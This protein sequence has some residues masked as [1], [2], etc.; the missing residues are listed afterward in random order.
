MG[1]NE[2]KVSACP[3]EVELRA[4]HARELLP[5]AA[6]A[7]DTHLEL[8]AACAS[9]A[10]ELLSE[11]ELWVDR[12]R[13]AGPAP[14]LR[15]ARGD[16]SA[17]APALPG[18]TELD[19]L[20]RGG[21]GVVYAATQLST[22]RRVALKV[23][24]DGVYASPKARR[25]FEREV[26]LVA[27]LQHAAIVT[28]HDFGQTPDGRQFLV[29]DLIEG[30][31]LLQA[32]PDLPDRAA[33]LRLFARICAAIA[34]AHRRGVIHRDL[35]PNNIL[36]DDAGEPH[37]LDFGL[38]R[39][40]ER[41]QAARIT[42]TERVAGTLP[43]MSP[44][45]A[46]GADDQIDVRSD[47]YALG[48]IL[49]ELLTGAYPYRVDGDTLEVLQNIT[50]AVPTRPSRALRAIGGQAP[51]TT[52]IDADLETI[53]LKA[54][55]KE[56]ERRYQ[57]AGELADDVTRHLAGEPIAARRDSH[58]YVLRKT[59][60]RYRLGVAVALAFVAVVTCSAVTLGLMASRQA[61][62]RAEAERR[63]A[64][65]RELAHAFVHEFDDEIR[66]L[67]GSANARRMVVARGLEYVDGLA[68]D[69]RDDPNLQME[70]AEAYVKI[71]DV[72]GGARGN[73]LGEYDAALA[74]YQ[75]ALR[76]LDAQRRAGRLSGRTRSLA[77]LAHLRLGSA[78]YLLGHSRDAMRCYEAALAEAER[79]LA[80]DPTSQDAA[81]RLSAAH[82]LI[83]DVHYEAGDYAVA[84]RHYELAAQHDPWGG[85]AASDD[86]WE[87]RGWAV[88]F[89]N[90]AN[91]HYSRGEYDQARALYER[92][93]G[94]A[95]AARQMHPDHSMAWMDVA[96]ARQWLGIILADS[97]APQQAVAHFQAS[98]D[99]YDHL[100][101]YDRR[102]TPPLRGLVASYSKLGEAQ[103][104]L[105]RLDDAAASFGRN[106][107]LAE[108]LVHEHPEYAG[109]VRLMGVAYYKMAELARR[110][111]AAAGL[112]GAERVALLREARDWLDQARDLFLDMQE[113]DVL[114]EMDSGAL[115]SLSVEIKSLDERLQKLAAD[116]NA[117]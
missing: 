65:V 17:T 116:P 5:E 47:V 88:K 109:G 8:C 98:I 93:L 67:P 7:L 22:K 74:S 45:Q 18:Y 2:A 63:F 85:A 15:S 54:L 75:K 108:L 81:E 35:K 79:W 78:H 46:R 69:A 92:F 86:A 77:S 43:Y 111:A 3:S 106:V 37:I 105:Q 39:P 38:A 51:S 24:S 80:D 102:A 16:A 9:R 112:A 26:E 103:L 83:G 101:Q 100:H 33:V 56:P 29:M 84:V 42:H 76:L 52:A 53:T 30:E 60:A 12:L 10:A 64:Q 90:L 36:V 62:L 94:I 99:A 91:V 1:L 20:G 70:L 66:H 107:E 82:E 95:E 59:L 13:S 32:A 19:E 113:R 68:S 31:P 40:V 110:R 11:H 28:V 114:A 41:G 34:Y 21:Q 87:R 4:Y 72:Q 50:E 25:R 104:A 57:S 96:T 44:E 6:A 73:N 97:G 48:V 14:R 71:G 117:G 49:Y 23:L 55:A 58:W 27:R 89:V 115:L 61:R